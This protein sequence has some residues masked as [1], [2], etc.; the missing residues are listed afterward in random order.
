MKS[1]W[2]EPK[3]GGLTPVIMTC[4]PTSSPVQALS[5]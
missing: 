5:V 2:C 3:R 1:P 4:G